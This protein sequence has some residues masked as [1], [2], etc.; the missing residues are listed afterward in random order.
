MTSRCFRGKSR[1]SAMIAHESSSQRR[2]L[3]GRSTMIWACPA[4]AGHSDVYSALIASVN[5]IELLILRHQQ[6][7]HLTNEMPMH[8]VKEVKRQTLRVG[9]EIIAGSAMIQGVR[10]N[11]FRIHQ[12]NIAESQS[13]SLYWTDTCLPAVYLDRHAANLEFR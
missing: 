8:E 12:R 1:T 4:R 11:L 6:S 5:V 9:V 3:S 7:Q 13:L 2:G 10:P